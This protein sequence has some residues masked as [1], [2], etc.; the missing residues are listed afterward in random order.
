MIEKIKLKREALLYDSHLYI[1]KGFVGIFI[2]Y[3]LFSGTSL[4]GK[5]MISV[6]FGLMLTLEPVNIS[7]IKSGLDQIK[8]TI[9]GGLITA[10]IVW[11]F[12]VNIITVPL[13]IA[14]T[15]YIALRINWKFV[16]PVAIFTAIYMTQYI[17]LNAAGETSM[18]LTFRLRMAALLSGVIIAVIINFVFSLIFYKSMIRKRFAYVLG[19]IADSFERFSQANSSNNETELFELKRSIPFI[20]TDIDFIHNHLSDLSREKKSDEALAYTRAL[21]KLRDLNHYLLDVVIDDIN[22]KDHS[23]YS[24]DLSELRGMVQ[25][26]KTRLMS[27]EK[28][29]QF[30]STGRKTADLTRI[31]TTIVEI[32]HEL[33]S[34]K[35]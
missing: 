23:N 28:I 16:S 31:E 32:S 18:L 19:Q 12:G 9:L 15:M 21:G 7:G 26:M 35:Y 2:A 22:S 8:A 27:K 20:F 1:L 3:L 10:V 24:K 4:V 6:L 33:S 11:I 13:A 17:Q 14:I 5:D 29:N 30:V 25:N 34:I